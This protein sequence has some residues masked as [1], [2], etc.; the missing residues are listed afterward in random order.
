[1]LFLS[2]KEYYKILY[3]R[4]NK[5]MDLILSNEKMRFFKLENSYVLEN[6]RIL[7]QF[8]EQHFNK[9]V[10]KLEVLNPL[11]TLKR[12]Y[13][14]VKDNDR[15]VSDISFIKNNDILKIE[16]RDGM[17]DAKVVKVGEK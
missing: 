9:L 5:S 6:P 4:L 8:K 2:K 13:A 14:I 16:F 15:V 11:N 1:M 3:Q 7:Y 12:G 10:E 17:V